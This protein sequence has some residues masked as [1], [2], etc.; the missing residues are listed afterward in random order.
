MCPNCTPRSE[1]TNFKTP[2]ANHLCFSYLILSKSNFICPF[3]STASFNAI[4]GRVVPLH[5]KLM[6]NLIFDEF[7]NN[8]IFFKNGDFLKKYGIYFKYSLVFLFRLWH[9]TLL[10]ITVKTNMR[11]NMPLPKPSSCLLGFVF[12]KT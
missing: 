1:I 3:I 11:Q 9:K 6:F 5:S 12:R 7:I 8:S 2:Q 4:K 10:P